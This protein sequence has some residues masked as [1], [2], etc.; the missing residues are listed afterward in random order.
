MLKIS[1]HINAPVSCGDSGKK[2]SLKKIE[3]VD[4]L[5]SDISSVDPRES[6]CNSFM[7]NM[8]SFMT[9]NRSVYI[10]G[11]FNDENNNIVKLDLMNMSYQ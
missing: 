3:V 7:S 4:Y 5:S 10:L 1:N 6:L 8:T 9:E 2:K 11:G